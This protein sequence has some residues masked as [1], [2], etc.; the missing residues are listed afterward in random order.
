M[1]TPQDRSWYRAPEQTLAPG[2]SEPDHTAEVRRVFLREENDDAGVSRRSFLRLV[3]FSFAAGGAVGCSRGPVQH[4]MTAMETSEDVVA[5]RAYWIASTSQADGSGSG[6]LVRCMDGRP[7]KLEGNPS[8]PLSKGGLTATSQASLLSLYDSRRFAGPQVDGQ[9][10]TWAAADARVTARMDELRRQDG[11]LRVLTSTLL[12]PSTQAQLAELAG[13]VPNGRVVTYDA[14]SCS[15]I[16]DAHEL[17]HGRRVLPHYD[18]SRAEVLVSFDADFLGTWISPAE[19]SAA[20]A[21]ARQPDGESAHM[22]RHWQLEARLSLSGSRADRRQR[23]APWEAPQALAA[24]AADLAQKAG[25]S[26]PGSPPAKDALTASLRATLAEIAADLWSHRKSALVLCGHNDRDAQVLVNFIN[27]LLQGYGTTLDLARPAQ[28]RQGDDKA[29][30]AL[31]TELLAGEVDMLVIGDGNPAYELPGFAEAMAN[32]GTVVCCAASLDETAALAEVVC[33]QPHELE[34]WD[35]AEPVAG[36]YCTT[37]PTI[38]S[39]RDTR[40]LRHSAARWSGELADDRALLMAYWSRELAPGRSSTGTVFEAWFATV[41]ERGW[42]DL[43]GATPSGPSV[44][45]QAPVGD[46]L[47]QIAADAPAASPSGDH[48]GL[49]LFPTV[50]LLDGRGAHNPWLQELPDP[51]T[52][53]VWDNHADL[54]PATAERLGLSQGDLVTVSLADGQ[55]GAAS[56]TLPVL[57]QPGQHDDVVAVALGYG[58]LGTDRFTN[59]GPAWLEGENTIDA[60][61][62]VGENGAMLLD[63]DDGQLRSDGA[64]VTLSATGGR[65]ELACTQD[66]HSL[67][68]PEHLAP[69][70]GEVR[71]AVAFLSFSE[72]QHDPHEAMAGAHGGH[73][74]LWADDHGKGEHQW[75]MAVDLASCTGCSACVVSCQ[76][77]N[78]VPVVGRDEVRR[79]REM[80]WLRIDRYYDD[81]GDGDVT[82]AHQPMMCQHCGHAPCETVCP[83]LATMHSAEGLNQQVYNRCVGTRYCANNCP[84][85]V[86]RFNWFDYP[87]E[88]RLQNMA[89]NP[90]VTVRSRGV[91]E[92]CS[93]CFQRI[94]EEKAAARAAG[95][96]LADG[97]IQMACQQSCPTQAIVFGDRNDPESALSKKL[98]VARTYGVLGELNLQQVVHYQA[99]VRNDD[100]TGEKSHG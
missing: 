55:A 52:K 70:G 3:G 91:M 29:L 42:V 89:L 92:K 68:V 94:Q 86:R 71:D 81:R 83:V 18:L 31:R 56:I 47:R 49:V 72:L 14:L 6:L 24:L 2:T 35:D 65:R 8:H 80:S 100:R 64:R 32:A 79:H 1:S 93:M 60:G 95:R 11:S 46:A 66:H 37:Q 63:L 59:V 76:A 75:G 21:E 30:L 39:L 23:L 7:I 16:L 57:V 99:D 4:A 43:Y 19:F 17:T 53:T 12:S 97:D 90:D 25:V 85:K 38:P 62:T 36:L 61:E 15:A 48:L 58:A 20:Y 27:D 96:E 82:V 33:P 26:L 73:S 41:L 88:D 9:E 5:G 40:T 67:A 45:T 28:Q 74:E 78:N 84:Y 69:K 13:T 22:S 54:S 87:R 51:V 44:M 10:S 98:A 34:R 50:G 77:E